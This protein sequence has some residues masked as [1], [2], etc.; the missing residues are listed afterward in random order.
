M[1]RRLACY[2]P[3]LDQFE[4][5]RMLSV[6]ASGNETAL[7]AAP[8]DNR[9]AGVVGRHVFYNNSRFD[10]GTPAPTQGDDGAIAV[11][12]QVLLPGGEFHCEGQ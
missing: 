12:K 1:P 2:H 3:A 8:L 7:V 5:R 6:S 11:D 4:Y 9:G 10:G